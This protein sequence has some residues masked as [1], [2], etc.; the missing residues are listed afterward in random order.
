MSQ[1]PKPTEHLPDDH[2]DAPGEAHEPGLG[3]PE[4]TSTAAPGNDDTESGGEPTDQEQLEEGWFGG[5]ANL[6]SNTSWM[7]GAGGVMLVAGASIG[8]FFVL[9]Q[10]KKRRNLFGMSGGGEG[11]R[12]A[13]APVSDEV[14]MGLLERSRRKFGVGGSG[15]AG[16]RGTKDLYDAFGDGPSDEDD[17]SD[18]GDADGGEAGVGLRYHDSFLEDEEAGSP[19]VRGGR[20]LDEEKVAEGSAY[21]DDDDLP[22]RE[23]REEDKDGEAS[24]ASGSSGSWQD[25][26]EEVGR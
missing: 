18:D 25:A 10:R 9:R 21:R 13:Y 1:K 14:P 26:A 17:L 24:G 20:V 6:A 3:H 8:G 11:A 16:A 5:V 22:P 2:A 4:T 7:A 12:G 23:T 19:V 15:G